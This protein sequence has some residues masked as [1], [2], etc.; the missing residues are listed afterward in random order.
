MPPLKHFQS[1]AKPA[2]RQKAR[3]GVTDSRKSR[4]ARRPRGQPKPAAG[5]PV[6]RPPSQRAHTIT[7]AL[8]V[9]VPF[10]GTMAAIALAWIYGMMDW[11]YLGMLLCGWL[12]TGLGITVG[13]HRL[14]AHRS[15]TTFRWLRAF[16][17]ILG[18][19]AVQG[20]PLV[21]CAIHR[22]HHELSDRPGD[23]HSPHLHGQHWWG[24]IKGFVHAHVGWLFHRY[25]LT[26]DLKRYV[27][28]LLKDRLLVW[29]DRCYVV[30]MLLSISL[31]AGLGYLWSESW[32]GAL[33][34][35]L[36][37]GLVRVFLV[38]H[39]TW[40]INSICHLFGTRDFR[41]ADHSRNNL[42]CGIL[43]LGEGWHNNHHAFPSSARHGLKWWQLDIS[44]LVILAMQRLGLAWDVRLPGERELMAKSL[45][46]L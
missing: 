2:A 43:G 26:V 18:A 32:K 39:I 5:Q 3:S 46:P 37:G 6:A 35:G 27:P 11:I 42:I 10:A 28:D 38:H 34:G 41:S 45:Q 19:C 9:S 13:F 25:W 1:Q 17:T 30:W 33:L 22:K 7:M 20:S 14:L 8:A 23:P 44:W 24:I 12:L 15:F 29:V 36:W 21:W 31:P 4:K 16:W 40:S